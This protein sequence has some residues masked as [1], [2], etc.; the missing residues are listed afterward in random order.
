MKHFR[1]F[2][3]ISIVTSISY[4]QFDKPVLQF[5]IG[6]V[7]PFDDLKGNY[8]RYDNSYNI[9]LL[10]PDTNLF[11][12]NYGA[13]TGLYFY[14]K[15]KINFDK[16]NIFRA[17]ASIGFNTFNTFEPSQSGDIGV[18]VNGTIYPSSATYNYTFNVFTVGIGL[19]IAPFAF[20]NVF[21]PYF[22]ANMTFNAMNAKLSRTEGFNDSVTFNASAF[23]IGFNIDCG[24][25]A[26]FS[27]IIG[28]VLGVK[29]DLGNLLLKN[30]SS[31][32]ADRYSWGNTNASLNDEQ[33]TYFSGLQS[34]ID[35]PPYYGLVNSKRKVLDWGTIYLGI[36]I[37]FPTNSNKTPQKK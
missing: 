32:I 23:R 1:L 24:L 33:G 3:L 22:G 7:Q 9:P 5:G 36:N 31:G 6:I 19:E 14:G 2:L 10:A 20:T 28:A 4:S 17:M 27:K 12:N 30:V 11:S 35:P 13:K 29:Y 34:P 16:Y 25:E 8:Y 37:Y 21:S 15:G 18:N 26:K